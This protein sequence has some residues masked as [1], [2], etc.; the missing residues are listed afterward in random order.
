[1]EPVLL[2]LMLLMDTNNYSILEK[3]TNTVYHTVQPGDTLWKISVRY[4]VGLS[5]LIAANP[6]IQNP[7]LIHPNQKILIPQR[8]ATSVAMEEKVIELTNKERT[9]RGLPALKQNWQLSRVARY[10]AE[11]MY[12]N[13]YFSH[14]SPTYGSP[15]DMMK[16]FNISFTAAGENI[17][18]GQRTPENVVTS[19]MN[20]PGHR[21]NILNKGF[22]EIGVGY[23]NGGGTPYWVQMFIHP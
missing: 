3:S 23:F 4:S 21:A 20:S 1:M 14:T 5:E 9:Q 15:F 16:A 7:A 17:A 18:M 12:H 10:K 13:N 11:D 2:M 8:D 22:S 19:W 6:Q